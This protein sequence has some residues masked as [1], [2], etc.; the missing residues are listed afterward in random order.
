MYNC[1]LLDRIETRNVVISLIKEKIELLNS[2]VQ[3]SL[4]FEV[5]WTKHKQLSLTTTMKELEARV[6]LMRDR[7]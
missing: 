4:D 1:G 7:S 6:I 3:K 5:A 2:I